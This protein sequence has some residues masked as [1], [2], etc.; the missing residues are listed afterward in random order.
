MCSGS[1]LHKSPKDALAVLG[2]VVEV[3]RGWDEAQ[4]RGLHHNKSPQF[5]ICSAYHIQE[6]LDG[7]TE[8]SLMCQRVDSG[9]PSKTRQ[10]IP[11]CICYSYNHH[12]AK[13][14]SNPIEHNTYE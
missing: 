5:G 2:K 8:S 6:N 7:R 1:F 14:S 4:P 10:S 11:C 3:T 12:F 13:C 9:N